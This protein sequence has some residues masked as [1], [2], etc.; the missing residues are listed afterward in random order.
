MA[1]IADKFAPLANLFRREFRRG[2]TEFD[3]LQ[4]RKGPSGVDNMGWL[5]L[6]ARWWHE[7]A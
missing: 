4:R 1:A 7:K 5:V 2:A 3:V 6:E